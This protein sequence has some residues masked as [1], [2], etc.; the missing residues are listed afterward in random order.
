MGTAT[1]ERPSWPSRLLAVTFYLGLAPLLALF[2]LHRRSAYLQH[3]FAQAVALVGLLAF[4]LL[5]DLV[6]GLTCTYGHVHHADVMKT[7]HLGVIDDV[8]S[9]VLLVPWAL[10]WLLAVV[11][12]LR[13][14]VWRV[15]LLWRLGDKRWTFRVTLVGN[16]GLG[17]VL[18]AVC[19]IA[20][21][22]LAITREADDR[23][24]QVY[25][26]YDAGGLPVPRAVFALGFYRIALAARERWGPDSVV[27]AP[28]TE[29]TLQQAMRHGR[30]VFL[31]THGREGNITTP[32]VLVEPVKGRFGG[33]LRSIARASTDETFWANKARR[34]EVG[35]NLQFVYV[36]ACNGGEKEETWR[37]ALTP[38]EVRT[39][40]RISDSGEHALWMWWDGPSRIR[41]ID[42]DPQ[43]APTEYRRGVALFEERKWADAEQAFR[44]AAELDPE[45]ARAHSGLGEAL[46][47][48]EKWTEAETACRRALACDSRHAV[49]HR[50]LG[51]ALLKQ[52]K[53]SQAEMAYRRAAALAPNNAEYHDELGDVLWEQKKW[54][55][56]EK[57][58]RRAA[59][60]NPNN[61]EY[62]NDLGRAL[63]EQREW[64]AAE[65]AHRRAAEV[66]TKNAAYHDDLGN[67]LYA[68]EKWAEGEKAYRQAAALDSNNAKYHYHLGSALL[69]R[70]HWAEAEIE[71]RRAAVIDSRSSPAHNQLGFALSMQ[72]KRTEAEMEYR[73]A[74][75]LDPKNAVAH[76][77]LGRALLRQRKWPEAEA[78]F[79]QAAEL[80]PKDA[81]AHSDLGKALRWQGKWTEAER[82]YRAA[83]AAGDHS[84]AVAARVPQMQ[85][86]AKLHPRLHAYLAG[87]LRPAG[88]D[89]RLALA[90]VCSFECLHASAV[91]FYA[92]AFAADA[93]LADDLGAWR[94]YNAACSAV[95]AAAGEG[96]DA[97]GDEQEKARLRGQ[98]LTWLKADLALWGQRLAAGK[99]S[100]P[101][102]VRDTLLFWQEDAD[103]AAVRDEKALAALPEG[104]RKE[105]A[106][107]WADVTGLL[108]KAGGK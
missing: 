45:W 32:L 102:A 85:L 15:P 36:C 63:Y 59:Q 100:G 40:P 29:D 9:A 7:Y 69:K 76:V 75:E 19:A 57:A 78:A 93:G 51:W 80:D 16:V 65:T 31:A 13:G 6:T 106:G 107:L 86:Q 50:N 18:A 91:R 98:A 58:Y 24:A 28:L 12:A 1:S 21:H 89:E 25:M 8:V 26:L 4:L 48:Q 53:W 30:F 83:I 47:Q 5:R 54:A 88:N 103:L 92:A 79:R 34:V 41:E 38:A 60:L 2:R 22:A 73:R 23:P 56:A 95:R 33:S 17:L 67:A 72:R 11:V 82:A 90:A 94:R 84:P 43:L 77:N 37:A 105:W 35:G 62:Q 27:V 97:P 20:L 96:C 3:H 99:D 64:A 74:A 46:L 42:P 55:E 49:D 52:R 10:L 71:Y 68:Q 61:A 66:A 104:E 87:D 44:Q 101:V 108:Q 14:S 81:T 39:F 70:R